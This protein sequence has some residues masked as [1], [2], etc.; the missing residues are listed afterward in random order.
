MLDKSFKDNEHNTALIYNGE[1]ISYKDLNLRANKLARLLISKGI[2]PEGLV[3]VCLDNSANL[4]VA[5]LAVLKAGGAYVP[6]DPEFPKDRISYILNDCKAKAIITSGAH[7]K[8]IA[9][10]PSTDIIDLDTH[11]QVIDWLPGEDI[12]VAIGVQNLAYVIYT[13]GT[14]GVP[15][16]VMIEHQSVVNN[17]L[18]SKEYLKTTPHDVVLQKTTFCFDVSVWEIFWALISGASLVVLNKDEVRD[19]QKLKDIIDREKVTI[20]H[21][22]PTM[23][24]LFLLAV[25]PGECSS[26][27]QVISSGEALTPFQAN[28]FKVKLPGAELHNLYG[29]T[30]ATIHATYWRAPLEGGEIK[31][32]LIGKPVDN[33]DIYILDE[34]HQQQPRD[35]IGEIYIGGLGVARGYLNRPLLTTQRFIEN[36]F[37]TENNSRLFKTGDFGRY[38]QNGSIEY[39]GRIDD[40]VKVNG[41]RIELGSVETTIKNSGVVDH[42]VILTRKNE[43]GFMQIVAYVTLKPDYSV[44]NVWDYLVTKLPGYMLPTSIRQI[45]NIPF[46]F[47]GKVDIDSLVYKLANET[48]NQPVA[49]K[50]ALEEV[51]LGI[52]R[53]VF[54]KDEISI[55]DNFFDLGGNSIMAVKMLSMLKKETDKH[56][57]FL[58][59]NQ[60]PTI[61]SLAKLLANPSTLEIPNILIP[62]KPD[63]TK[64]PIYMINGGGLVADG[65]FN[66]SDE[67]DEDQPVFGFQSNGFDSDGN[68]FKTIEDIA[69]FYIKS[70][71]AENEYGPYCLA[72]YS[73]GGIIAFEMAKQLTSMGKEIKL[74]AIIDGLSR[75]PELIKTRYNLITGLRMIGLNL[76]L[77]K[78]GPMRALNYTN[79]VFKAI[80]KTIGNRFSKKA[81]AI[82]QMSVDEENFDV[83]SLHISAYQ[84]YQLTPYVGNIV[85]FRA[86]EITFYMDDFKYLGWKRFAKKAK[87]ITI[88]GHHFSIFDNSNIR[89]FGKK[90]QAVLDSGF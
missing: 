76:Y 27:R 10:G 17:L 18:W 44:Q 35:R 77:L 81:P 80:A 9:S 25:N 32:I 38:L 75:D 56:V 83:F 39:L 69:A 29:P 36:I 12:D 74:L 41:Y 8:K 13:S 37:D 34:K 90:L 31:K 84:K 30:E 48:V 66:L 72:G 67:L 85:V 16:G 62:I 5:L 55:Y 11:L 51:V 46:T 22:V 43:R 24:E 52:W 71:L 60:Y 86:S 63:G 26:L 78:Y 68:P 70:L 42:A 28:L 89:D 19:I 58:L 49:P 7:I 40:Q 3:P 2:E 21:F 1:S 59:L 57:S 65:F 14:T 6:I 54:Q 87:S 82:T 53:T 15:N 88:K 61:Q 64:T 50:T 47:N 20:T 33:T 45:E 4:I 79:G 73:L 23:L